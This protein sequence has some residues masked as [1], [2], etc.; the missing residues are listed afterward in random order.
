MPPNGSEPLAEKTAPEE[1]DATPTP[2]AEMGDN[3]GSD[4]PKTTT[5]GSASSKKTKVKPT[6]KDSAKPTESKPR[7]PEKQKANPPDNRKPSRGSAR[8]AN[9]STSRGGGAPLTL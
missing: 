3:R 9:A 6:N 7:G 5:Q 1:E 2:H 8:I 4:G